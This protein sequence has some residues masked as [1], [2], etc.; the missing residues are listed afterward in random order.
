MPLTD[1]NE[2]YPTFQRL[3]RAKDLEGLLEL[4]EPNAKIA[5][6]PGRLVEGHEAIRKAL[7][8]LL[9]LGENP[10][11]TGRF[12]YETEDGLALS[13]CAYTVGMISGNSAELLRRQPDGSWK[14]VL[15]N[16]FA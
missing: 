8:G 12:T 2:L 13:S 10:T 7:E 6:A 3:A 5:A 14:Y 9:S 16:P 1:L 4:Y 15:D 11:L